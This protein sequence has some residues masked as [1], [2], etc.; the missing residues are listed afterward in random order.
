MFASTLSNAAK[1]AVAVRTA[2]LARPCLALRATP[3]V[4]CRFSPAQCSSF[5]D[6][7]GGRDQLSTNDVSSLLDALD[8]GEAPSRRSTKSYQ[9][10]AQPP[11][12]RLFKTK[13]QKRFAK[14]LQSVLARLFANDV[15]KD[16]VLDMRVLDIVG[17]DFSR[18]NKIATVSW[19]F[20]DDL[21]V[22]EMDGGV[23]KEMEEGVDQF[24]AGRAKEIQWSAIKAMGGK[25][26][27]DLSFEK[28]RF[29]ELE[30][31]SLELIEFVEQYE[32]ARAARRGGE[33][34]AVSKTGREKK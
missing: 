33:G 32:D 4:V 31:E 25:R 29:S 6:K 2:R 16:H 11:R 10:H 8:G 34:T 13:G 20:A 5:H 3:L 24:L 17:V 9:R 15:L 1:R 30:A 26:C 18:D 14:R 28:D 19:A 22:D 23:V 27:P 12:G 7:R 21:Q